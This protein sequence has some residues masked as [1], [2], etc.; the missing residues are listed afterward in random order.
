MIGAREV[1]GTCIL[2]WKAPHTI[3]IGLDANML[4]L[5]DNTRVKECKYFV[6]FF[7]L[8]SPG[9]VSGSCRNVNIIATNNFLV[10]IWTMMVYKKLGGQRHLVHLR[11]IFTIFKMSKFHLRALDSRTF[12]N[13]VLLYIIEKPISWWLILF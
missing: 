11:P 7:N 4:L 8:L 1:G 9:S 10:F 13:V 6:L 5:Q 12:S 3:Q 2:S